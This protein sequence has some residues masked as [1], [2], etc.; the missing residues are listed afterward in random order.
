[1]PRVREVTL[2]QLETLSV[3][4]YMRDALGLRPLVSSS[5][6]A[7]EP[8]VE[9]RV[10]AT[11][12]ASAAMLAREW[13]RWWV[14]LMAVLVSPRGMGD[15]AQWDGEED[16]VLARQPSL[17]AAAIAL[18]VDASRWAVQRRAEFMTLRR[19]GR[20]RTPDEA[21]ALP[22]RRVLDRATRWR[23][24]R[25]DLPSWVRIAV[26]PVESQ[27]CVVAPGVFL[28]STTLLLDADRCADWLR[29]AVS[30]RG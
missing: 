7:L 16:R 20:A 15:L 30:G 6:P 17:Y 11:D 4:L 5:I 8:T 26:L 24:W 2:G 12:H 29:L 13:E 9:V 28:I 18:R 21:I 14:D 19:A 3:A 10:G 27:G 23:W 1:M 22:E 25:R